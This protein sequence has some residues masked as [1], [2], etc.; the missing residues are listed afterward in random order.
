[1]RALVTAALRLLGA[2]AEGGQPPPPPLSAPELRQR[3]DRWSRPRQLQDETQDDLPVEDEETED[4]A[5]R[6][7]S[8]GIWIAAATFVPTFL[9]TFFGVAYL[10]S[11]PMGTRFPPGLKGGPPPVTSTLAPQRDFVATPRQAQA[12]IR[13]A[14]GNAAV[15]ATTPAI[16]RPASGPTRPQVKPKADELKRSTSTA[17]KKDDAWVRAAAFSD[18]DSAERLAAS[19][20][21][22]GYPA[23]VRRGD[24]AN[25]PW[26]VWI[27]KHPRGMTPSERRK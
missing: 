11:L 4:I 1:M 10:A 18:R 13:E 27:G 22:Q 15:P 25:T 5:R 20:E 21:Q 7:P 9:A 26:V 24:T 16:P 12:P 8:H 6:G 23:K 2:S 17:P 14:L 19:I 3:V